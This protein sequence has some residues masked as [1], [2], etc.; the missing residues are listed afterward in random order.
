MALLDVK[1]LS[2]SYGAIRALSDVSIAVE[3]REIVSVIGANGA[4]KS[5]LMNAIMGMVKRDRGEVYLDG[6]LL[7][8]RS[9]QVVAQGIALSPEGRKVFAPLTVY[10]NLLMGAFPRSDRNKIA[11]DMEWVYTLFPRL[12]ERT[13]QYAGTLS[14]GEQQMLAIARALMARPRVLLLDEPSL[15][16]APIIIKEIFKELRR[17]NEEGVT[18]LLV[19][20]NA[21]QALLLSHR[22]YV[23]QTGRLILSGTSKELLANPEVEAAYLGGKPAT[24]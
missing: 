17:I 16:L 13:D 7:A 4:G 5:T 1:N 12:R 15:G 9:F 6:K 2:V 8:E 3:E 24:H 19:E 20:Q 22:A 11:E 18:I 21:R 14:G 10:E 23:L